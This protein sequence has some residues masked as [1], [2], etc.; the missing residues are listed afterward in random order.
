VKGRKTR[1]SLSAPGER[2][3][4]IPAS[5]LTRS[6]WI[7]QDPA[8][9]VIFIDVCKRHNGSN[10]DA[11]GY[12]SAAGAKA[13]NV[14][15]STANRRLNELRKGG[16]LKLRR[17]G[18]FNIKDREKQT[19]EWEI[20]IFPVVGR[21]PSINCQFGER[22]I[23][24]EHWLLNSAAYI[25]LSNSAKCTFFE[26][27]RRFDGNNNGTISF[28][29][30]DGGYIGLNRDQTERALTELEGARFIVETAPA[31]VRNGVPR[32]WR[33]TIYGAIGEKATK[34]FM[35]T[36]I[37]PKKS[38]HG[39]TGADDKALNVSPVRT[40]ISP[41]SPVPIPAAAGTACVAN[42][43]HENYPVSDIRA[44]DTFE[45]SDIRTGDMHIET[46]PERTG[47]DPAP[48][49]PSSRPATPDLGSLPS[50][51]AEPGG[52]EVPL[53]G[54]DLSAAPSQ[55]ELLRVDLKRVLALT[56]RGTQTRIAAGLGLARSTFS[57]ALAGRERFA[58]TAATVLR[59]WVNAVEANP[60]SPPTIEEF[61]RRTD[62]AA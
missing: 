54:G 14:S 59:Q 31:E 53:F 2:F 52:V 3:I 51:L 50:G 6:E 47:G 7:Q 33:L 29:G 32:K 36:E 35:R 9:R 60:A 37:R 1:V 56:P 39:V 11:I 16:L 22:R 5:L 55:L 17:E 27:M 20:T 49:L 19:R 48:S 30:K 43:L 12:G 4:L 46:I 10:N 42:R 38:F 8:A 28:G 57:H 44:G 15:A 40:T 26:L 58:S 21:G 23:K 45:A 34:D 18:A 25:A 41:M 13:A 62:D 24:F 61:L